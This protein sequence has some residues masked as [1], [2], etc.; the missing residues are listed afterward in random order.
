MKKLVASLVLA[1]MTAFNASASILYF[2][3]STFG[4]TGVTFDAVDWKSGD[5]GNVTQTDTNNNGSMFGAGDSFTEFGSTVLTSFQL[6]NNNLT[7][8]PYSMFLD[9]NFAGN[10][11]LFPIPFPF[12][13]VLFS[14][15]T[16]DLRIGATVLG[17]FSVNVGE[18]LIS[19]SFF[20][21]SCDIRMMFNANPGYFF[22]QGNDIAG[23][24]QVFSTLAVTV[25]QITGLSTNYNGNPGSSQNFTIT[26]DG[27]QNFQVPEPTSL[28]VLGLGLLGLRLSRRSKV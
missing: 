20:T 5:T 12:L 19:A 11:Q 17:S 27:N 14:S 26:H 8:V 9:Y 13:Q 16:A 10:V 6:N 28:A 1:G 18:C 15:G 24:P 4:G 25:Q 21:G 3:D 7:S 2:D 22:Y 23:N